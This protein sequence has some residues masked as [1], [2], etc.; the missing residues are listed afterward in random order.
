MICS[1][2]GWVLAARE[3]ERLARFYGLVLGITVQSGFSKH[4]WVLPLAEGM[5]LEIYRPS[6]TRAFPVTGRRLAPCLRLPASSSPEQALQA[7]LP[8]LLSAGAV[9]DEPPRLEP[10]GAETWL[11]DPEANALLLVVPLLNEEAS[12]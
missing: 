4:H 8:E 12:R 11:L 10:F 7:L 9:I 5:T 2:L 6:R 3:P 1:Q